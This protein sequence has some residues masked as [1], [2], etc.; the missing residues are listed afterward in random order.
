MWNS[1]NLKKKKN[2]QKTTLIYVHI[3][4]WPL[5]VTFKK[6]NNEKLP[7]KHQEKCF[8]HFLLLCLCTSHKWL[9]VFCLHL[10]SVVCG[11]PGF[12]DSEFDGHA[13]VPP[14]ILRL[15]SGI[16]PFTHATYSHISSQE[17]YYIRKYF[18]LPCMEVSRFSYLKSYLL[19]FGIPW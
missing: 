8:L 15:D 12:L 1:R 17:I 19:H 13:E 4:Q 7:P 11:L 3:S 9:G 14:I 10:F 5:I 18:P 2:N 16:Q 6:F